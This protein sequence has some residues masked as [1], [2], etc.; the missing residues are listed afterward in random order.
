MNS[1]KTWA[2]QLMEAYNRGFQDG[3]ESRDKEW[4]DYVNDM[5]EIRMEARI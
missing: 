4:F 5:E 2:E 3:Y 1:E